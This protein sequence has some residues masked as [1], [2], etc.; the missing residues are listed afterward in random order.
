MFALNSIAHFTFANVIETTVFITQNIFERCFW[1]EKK[2]YLE[3]TGISEKRLYVYQLFFILN[4]GLA[5][6][7]M[8]DTID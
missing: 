6:L 5:T 2:H 8:G 4:S 3:F 7:F 1:K